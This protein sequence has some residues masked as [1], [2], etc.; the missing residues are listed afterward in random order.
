[1]QLTVRRDLQALTSFGPIYILAVAAAAAVAIY[2]L[3]IWADRQ[4]ATGLGVTGMNAPTYWGAYIVNF[5]FFVGL[6]AGGI[7]VSSLV[8]AL[9]LERYRPV[10]RIAE[11][12][13]IICI[14]LAGIFITI[15]I[16]RPDRL[17]HLARYG[18]WESPLIWDV[19]I[20]NVYLAMALA[21]GYFSTRV[22]IVKCMRAMPSR[23]W[24]Y[25]LLALGYVDVSPE[26]I[27]RDQKILRVLA[28]ASIPAAVLLHSITAWIMGLT[29]ATP[30]WHTALL[31]PVFVGSALVSGLALVTLVSFA[32]QR[33]F[34]A[35]VSDSTV[36]G[37]GRLIMLAIPLLGYFLFSELLTVVYAKEVSANAFF[38]E[39]IKGDYAIF[40]WF[41]LLVGLVAPTLIL[42]YVFFW[43]KRAEAAASV[44]AARSF[45]PRAVTVGLG[46][47]A[48][49]LAVLSFSVDRS[50]EQSVSLEAFS[51][52]GTA[53]AIVLGALAGILF[54]S[55]APRL[56]AAGGVALAS[57]LVVAGVLAER[58]NIVLAPQFTRF[59]PNPDE[60][61]ALPYSVASY[62]PTW[63][64]ISIIVGV[65][66]IGILGFL[67]FAKIFPL[68]DLTG[69]EPAPDPRTRS[70]LWD[71]PDPARGGS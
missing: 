66:A 37:L 14:L 62:H 57:A 32:S 63:E 28:F 4:L 13:A 35:Q 36:A 29:K 19:I 45:A 41:D 10:A 3:F 12:I 58:I 60:L 49:A 52:S 11:V 38:T 51:L 5:V 16:G 20:V 23:A 47:I 2:A 7:I 17:W 46:G 22:D 64:E 61:F 44:R 48:L 18:R 70:A 54:V 33:L 24:L 26:A 59:S 68:T 15:D 65:Y 42:A 50:P 31:A 6:S 55:L 27:R 71:E 21:L 34:R 30:G 40:F 39:L 43:P 67:A 1:M 9:N 25:R 8:H 53:F 69:E 56:S